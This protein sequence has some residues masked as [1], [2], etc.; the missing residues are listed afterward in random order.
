MPNSSRRHSSST[1]AVV[2]P[3]SSSK[4][5]PHER[6]RVSLI[7]S[8]L[9]LDPSSSGL[10]D[11]QWPSVELKEFV[12]RDVAWKPVEG[13]EFEIVHKFDAPRPDVRQRNEA[14]ETLL[15]L[16]STDKHLLI[17]ES[18]VRYISALWI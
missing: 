8:S 15:L 17:P 16:K 3:A 9:S 1:P 12:Q 10:K 11:L 2:F 5:I 6:E 13:L 4:Q 18:G 7:N 14:S